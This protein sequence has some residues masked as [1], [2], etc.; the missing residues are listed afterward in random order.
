MFV[1]GVPLL[2]KSME[3]RP[4]FEAYAKRTNKFFPWFPKKGV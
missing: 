4:G 1:S 2:E 3:K